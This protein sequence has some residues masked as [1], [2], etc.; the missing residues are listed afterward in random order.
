MIPL[1]GARR[2]LL[3]PGILIKR[4]NVSIER[5][6]L[7]LYS[8]L[9]RSSLRFSSTSSV[10]KSSPKKPGNV[11]FPS[12]W[13]KCS[14]NVVKYPERLLIYN[15]GTGRTVFIGCLKITTIFV[16]GFFCLV[17]APAHYYAPDEPAWIAG[18]GV[19]PLFNLPSISFPKFSCH[20]QN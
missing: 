5:S 18:V 10:A 20:M 9:P 15:A 17:V 6:L 14:C 19:Y 1:I 3:H 8:R 4:L 12:I 13:F 2:C 11:Q 16:F 7:R